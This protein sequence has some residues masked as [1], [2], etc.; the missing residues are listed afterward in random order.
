MNVRG[1]CLKS[2]YA[3]LILDSERYMVRILARK[4]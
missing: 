2:I 3:L 1:L 4:C